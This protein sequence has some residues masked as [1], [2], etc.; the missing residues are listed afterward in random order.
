MGTQGRVWNLRLLPAGGRW[1]SSALGWGILSL[2][3]LGKSQG[4]EGASGAQLPRGLRSEQQGAPRVQP[5]RAIGSLL[6]ED[7]SEAGVFF[8]IWG[9]TRW[10]DMRGMN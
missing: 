9:E 7:K 1:G 4:G 5:S 3:P 10:W 2:L 6:P 8:G